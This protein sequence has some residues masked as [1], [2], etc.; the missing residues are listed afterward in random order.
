MFFLKEE[1]DPRDFVSEGLRFV[2]NLLHVLVV[3]LVVVVVFVVVV[4]AL[5]GHERVEGG[6]NR[7]RFRNAMMWVD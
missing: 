2:L 7:R 3:V 1:E 6:Q 4:T 5:P